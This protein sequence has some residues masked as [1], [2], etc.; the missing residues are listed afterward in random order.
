MTDQTNLDLIWASSG[1]VT[2]PGDTKYATGWVS[3]IPSYQNFNFVLQAMSSN[4]LSLAEKGTYSWEAGI[5][6]EVGASVTESGEKFYCITSNL[7][8]APST[9]TTSS[10]WIK[11]PFYGVP[12]GAPKKEQGLALR[13]VNSRTGTS[14]TSSDITIDNEQALIQLNTANAGQTNWL[15]GNVS[16]SLVAV[17][18]GTSVTADGRS[19][20]PSTT[21]SHKIFHE[22]NLPTASQVSGVVEE[23]PI[24]GLIYGRNNE[25]WVAVVTTSVSNEP[26]PASVGAGTGWYNLADGNMYIDI[27]DGDS[28]QWVPANPPQVVEGTG[29]GGGSVGPIQTE[30]IILTAGQT[31][32]VFSEYSTENSSFYIS[33]VNVDSGRLPSSAFTV[34][35]ASEI[36]LTESYPAGTELKLVRNEVIGEQ[37]GV[38]SEVVSLTSGQSTV[39]FTNQTTNGAGF[40]LSGLSVDSGRLSSID[41][42]VIDD[43]SIELYQSY[44]AGTTVTLLRDT[45]VGSPVP[46]S[47]MYQD[48]YLFTDTDVTV[49]GGSTVITLRNKNYP[50]TNLLSLYLNGVRQAVNYDYTETSTQVTIPVEIVSVDVIDISTGILAG[51]GEVTV[52]LLSSGVGSPEGVV[53]AIVGSMYTDT[54]GGVGT[55]LYVKETGSS[56]TGWSAK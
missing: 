18:A 54:T 38:V 11:T 20:V 45:A 8:N 26:P 44:P 6:Y 36:T 29:S 4:I 46:S 56:S 43:N 34:V 15:L 42:Y 3:E 30:E 39:V 27:N 2:D 49:G 51:T 35:D 41:Y 48:R 9:D 13:Q 24:D 23:A 32:V 52:S 25:Q 40:Y 19:L 55:T 17:D 16:G 50:G 37:P 14:W 33:G 10:Y 7:G 31:S 12:S 5:N 21:Y 53:T 1:G 47:T 28:S 22:G